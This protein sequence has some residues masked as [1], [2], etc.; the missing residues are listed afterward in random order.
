M[1]FKLNYILLKEQQPFSYE[2]GECINYDIY[3]MFPFF[4]QPEYKILF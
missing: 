2:L 4:K 1:L 3:Y